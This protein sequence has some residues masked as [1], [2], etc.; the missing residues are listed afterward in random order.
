[1]YKRQVSGFLDAYNEYLA[2]TID[3][4]A[5]RFSMLASDYIQPLLDAF[6]HLWGAAE[7]AVAAFWEFISPFVSWLSEVF[8]AEIST[9]LS[10]LWAQFEGV[11][12]LVS[13]LLTL[14]L[15]HI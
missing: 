8:F 4:I 1:M 6:L 12:S 15:I 2:P 7:E 11:F 10:E 13:T 14:S 3:W 9:R 5:D